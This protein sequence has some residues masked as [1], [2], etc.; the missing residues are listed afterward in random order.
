[1]QNKFEESVQSYLRALEINNKSPECH[2][3]L[4]SA[5]NDL[6]DYK[7]AAKHYQKSIELEEGNVD[8]YL[9]LGQ[10][11]EQMNNLD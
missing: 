1:M 8:A 3:N 5:Y 11:M 6:G 7:Q 2:F 10:V 4:A 9:C